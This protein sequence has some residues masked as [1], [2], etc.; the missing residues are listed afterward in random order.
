MR[1]PSLLYGSSRRVIERAPAEAA[2]WLAACTQTGSIVEP[3]M[4]ETAPGELVVTVQGADLMPDKPLW[5]L[6]GLKFMRLEQSQ[7][8]MHILGELETY[9]SST[10][11]GALARC[12]EQKRPNTIEVVAA[13]MQALFRWWSPLSTLRYLGWPAKLPRVVDLS[14][15][16]DQYLTLEELVVQRYQEMLNVWSQPDPDVPR[17]IENA[18]AA[19]S[20]ASEVDAR[21][22]LLHAMM[23]LA[24]EDY[25][26][27]SWPALADPML[28]AD[29]YDRASVDERAALR[30]GVLVELKNFLI[31]VAR[32]LPS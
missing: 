13:R 9:M 3:D 17:R 30:S 14:A 12:L 24:S 32:R 11:W 31:G 7:A 26:L 18:L 23:A 25:R 5:R 21:S 4:R 19:M 8:P 27:R 15:P 1:F 28:L 29:E 22:K 10:P 2:I 16:G 6:Y 20:A